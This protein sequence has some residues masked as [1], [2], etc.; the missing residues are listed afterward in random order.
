MMAATK[1]NQLIDVF[2]ASFFQAA[3]GDCVK[4]TNWFSRRIDAFGANYFRALPAAGNALADLIYPPRCVWCQ[5]DLAPDATP[6][7]R[8]AFCRD[9]R[10]N[11]APPVAS[12]CLRC[13]APADGLAEQSH[14]CGHC[15]RESFPWDRMV[16]LGRYG[17]ELSQAIVRTKRPG[18][19]PLTLSLGQLLF[20]RRSPAFRELPVQAVVPMP[21]HRLRR[22]RRGTNGPDL[23]AEALANCL[24]LPLRSAALR[25]SRLTPLQVDVN[26]SERQ[27]HQR[28]SFRIGNKRH[29][30]DRH[31]LLV[32]DVLTTGATAAEAVTTL[33]EG[34]AKTV[35]VAALAR[36]IGDDAL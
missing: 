26:P 36:A 17:G 4:T 31:L 33:L 35:S 16:A 13:G 11:L 1:T 15:N 30:Q 23:I 27:L 12:W 19:E 5:I 29:I 24:R 20:N 9:C 25:R 21:I 10:R 2:E 34:G 7:D 22:I 32:D 18:N 28:K 14:G 6:D 3:S 8:I